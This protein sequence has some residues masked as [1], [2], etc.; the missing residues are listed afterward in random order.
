[1]FSQ[2]RA[3]TDI[4][5][6]LNDYAGQREVIAENLMQNICVELLRFSQDLKQERKAHLQEGRK[7]Q[8]H[9]DSS[10]KQLDSVS[11]AS[12]KL[13]AAPLCGGFAGGVGGE[14]RGWGSW[15]GS[16]ERGKGLKGGD[17]SGGELYSSI[18]PSA[19]FLRHLHLCD[20]Y[21]LFADTEQQVTPIIGKCLEGVL[22]AANS[23]DENQDSRILIESYKSGF[24]RPSELEFEDYSQIINR[25]SSENSLGSVKSDCRTEQR[26]KSKGKR[27][28][29]GK[30]SKV[31]GTRDNNLHL[32]TVRRGG[33][34]RGQEGSREPM[35]GS[36]IDPFGHWEPVEPGKD[37]GDGG[38]VTDNNDNIWE[39]ELTLF[40]LQAWLGDAESKMVSRSY[41]QN[42]SGDR[43]PNLNNGSHDKESS[44]DTTYSDEGGLEPLPSTPS[45]LDDFEEEGLAPAIGSSTALYSFDGN[46]EGTISMAEGE[47]LQL[48]EEDKGD[49]WTRVRRGD[50]E[51]GYIPTSYVQISLDR[52]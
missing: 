21:R 39:V 1:R 25:T 37:W 47:T 46:S 44:P 30:K 24:E 13:I 10:F 4:L 40:V 45:E 42:I 48:I 50:G 8:Q 49:G 16:E 29:F 19:S 41:V 52:K 22:K 27:W 23:V 51:E 7:A 17:V 38:G 9:L 35:R 2:F 33:E 28:L 43:S 18:P 31:T 12:R 5:N 14:Q 26:S 15:V 32:H 11:V 20:T 3:F 6:E 36:E 34:V